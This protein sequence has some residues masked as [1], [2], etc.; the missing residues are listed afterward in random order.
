MA[1]RR[2]QRIAREDNAPFR[3][4]SISTGEVFESGRTTSLVVAAGDG[5]WQRALAA[6]QGEYRRALEFGFTPAEVAEQLAIKP[7]H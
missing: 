4:A 3:G 2:F 1:G 6:A 5:E 7:A